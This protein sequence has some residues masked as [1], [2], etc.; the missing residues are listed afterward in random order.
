[1]TD[2][3]SRL[4]ELLFDS[5]AQT[6][7]DLSARLEALAAKLQSVFERSGTAQ[8]F[9]QS[10]ADVLDGALRKAE[11]ER[12]GEL[13]DAVAPLVVNT[14]RTE[15]TNSKD[16]LVEA[17]YPVTG[18][19]VKAYVA[20]AM[21]DLADQINR[22]LETNP[23]ML[24]L[25]SIATGRSMSELA[26]AET[27]RLVVEELYLIRRGTGELV[28]RWPAD[29]GTDRDQVMT[30][31]LTA[32]NEFASEAFSAENYALRQ[33]DLGERQVYLRASPAYLLAA[34]CAGT[35]PVAVEQV[36]DDVFLKSIEAAQLDTGSDVGG[37]RGRQL[38]NSLSSDLGTRIEEAQEDVRGARLGASPVK[39]LAWLIG[40]P[41]LGWL[42]WWT[43]SDYQTHRVSVIASQ[44][45]AENEGLKEYPTRLTIGRLGSRLMIGGLA[46]TENVRQDVVRKLKAALPGVDV[47]EELAVVPNAANELAPE[48]ARLRTEAGR[49]RTETDGIRAEAEKLGPE[50]AGMRTGLTQF[51]TRLARSALRREIERTARVLTLTET[52]LALAAQGLDGTAR[53]GAEKLLSD[54]KARSREVK[55]AAAIAGGD[56]TLPL[57]ASVN[58]R[59]SGL[60]EQV[61][62]LTPRVSA[63]AG[64]PSV[65]PAAIPPAGSPIEAAE[66]LGVASDRLAAAALALTQ[67][68][69]I[70]KTIPAPVAIPPPVL[71]TA[72]ER[73]ASWVHRHAI[74]FD[75]DQ[76]YR[77]PAR[78]EADL[79]ELAALVKESSALIRVVGYT[80]ALGSSDRNRGLRQIRAEKVAGDLL[81]RGVPA[82]QVVALGRTDDRDLSISTG[83]DSSNRRV[84]FELGFEGERAQ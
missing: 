25:R 31:V 56:T 58:T 1:M 38:V 70:K 43:Y 44:I 15:I 64:V 13:C 45:I 24:G 23:M 4:K 12:H 19:I 69:A 66:Q 61:R 42:A 21:K 72:R 82:A 49:L 81:A 32:I 60:A 34:K 55:D 7:S 74:F 14:V 11:S 41:L 46:P 77:D 57:D 71:P 26:I 9:E 76:N 63:L 73:L 50:L 65:S 59:L 48:I 53:S 20:S 30:G 28:A 33:I 16:M 22:R 54:L 35:A 79:V 40:V 52:D 5:E 36:V 17:L 18:R 27:Q 80:D 75:E 3:V 68:L 83:P 29:G 51:E 78:A 2:S 8:S 62:A 67:V 39:I 84:E 47:T 37:E 6:L 10:V